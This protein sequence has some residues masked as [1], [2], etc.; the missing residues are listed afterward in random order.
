MVAALPSEVYGIT[1]VRVEANPVRG[2]VG[3]LITLQVSL[4]SDDLVNA[5][6]GVLIFDP[7]FFAFREVLDAN[8]AVTV[9]VEKPHLLYP[10]AIAFAGVTPGGLTGPQNALFSVVFESVTPGESVFSLRDVIILKH[11]GLGTPV[12]DISYKNAGTRIVKGDG[13]KEMVQLVDTLPPEGFVPIVAKDEFV[14]NGEWFVSFMTHDKQSSVAHYEVREYRIPL[15][16]MFS[17]WVTAQSPYLL[18]D[19]ERKSTIQVR[20]V[21]TYGNKYVAELRAEKSPEWWEYWQ[22]TALFLAAGYLIY[23]AVSLLRRFRR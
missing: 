23:K 2:S 20:A 13:N 21:D 8:T 12:S 16:A 7:E 17:P 1:E 6:E 4:S 9:W 3:D 5:L 14:F 15:L 11:D 10:G 18:S 19:Q 22:R